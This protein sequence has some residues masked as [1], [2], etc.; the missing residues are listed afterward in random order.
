MPCSDC[1][2]ACV[3]VMRAMKM[4][5]ARRLG[6]RIVLSQVCTWAWTWV[7]V[8]LLLEVRPAGLGLHSLSC[9]LSRFSQAPKP[10]TIHSLT[11]ALISPLVWRRFCVGSDVE[12]LLVTGYAWTPRL[13]R[14]ID[15]SRLGLVSKPYCEVSGPY[16]TKP[17]VIY[18]WLWLLATL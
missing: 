16:R 7:L 4:A 1:M 12:D 8:F 6:L 10:Y 17:L 15:V 11:Q 5:K 18:A 3:S 9:S 13:R 14:F 2:C